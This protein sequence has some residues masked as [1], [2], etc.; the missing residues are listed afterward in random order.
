[1]AKQVWQAD[2]GTVFDTEAEALAYEKRIGQIADLSRFIHDNVGCV[3]YS[4][5]AREIAEHLLAHYYIAPK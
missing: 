1:M 3:G 2:N 4:E 5:D